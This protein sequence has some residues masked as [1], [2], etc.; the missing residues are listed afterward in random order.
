MQSGYSVMDADFLSSDRCVFKDDLSLTERNLLKII[1][2]EN[3]SINDSHYK[4]EVFKICNETVLIIK[5]NNNN[6]T[7]AVKL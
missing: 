2:Y 1:G 5:D 7:M 3:I 4:F 6:T